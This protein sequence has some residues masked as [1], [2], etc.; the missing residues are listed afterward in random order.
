[1]S[2]FELTKTRFREG[3]WEGLLT[4]KAKDAGSPEIAVT[5]RDQPVR[6]VTVSQTSQ[7]GR[8]VVE[9]PVPLDALG[10]GV[11][12]FLILDANAE[13]VLDSFTLIA[14]EVL[15]DDIRA[16]VELLRAELDM[17]KRAFRRHCLE[18]T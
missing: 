18:T 8:W 13:T 7:A 11:Q 9:I 14:G 10:D 5:L 4:T 15:G 6:G 12:T 1:M 16:E 17:L 2:Q 3:V